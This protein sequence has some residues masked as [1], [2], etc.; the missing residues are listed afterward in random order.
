MKSEFMEIATHIASVLLI[1]GIFIAIVTPY[2][3]IFKKAGFHPGLSLT[4]LIPLVNI[5]VLYYVAFSKWPA[6]AFES[7]DGGNFVEA[8]STE[9]QKDHR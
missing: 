1:L 4:I 5:I 2:W 9:T 8:G 3:K 7:I 6:R